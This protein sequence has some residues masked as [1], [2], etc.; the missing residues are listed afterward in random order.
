MNARAIV[1]GGALAFAAVLSVTPVAAEVTLL[2]AAGGGGGAGGIEFG[3]PGQI[4][5]SGGDSDGAGGV[6]GLGGG[7]TPSAPS[8]ANGAGGAGWLGPGASVIRPILGPPP[9]AAGGLSFPTFGGGLSISGADGG[10]GGGGGGGGQ[11]GGG[12]G[13]YSGGGG[14]AGGESGGGGGSYVSADFVDP[15][16]VAGSLGQFDVPSV[17]GWVEINGTV[18]GFTG[19]IAEY[20]VPAT[21]LYDILAEGAQGGASRTGFQNPGG[22]GAEVGGDIELT[23]GTELEIVVGG[24]GHIGNPAVLGGG[25]GGG[26]FVWIASTPSAAPEPSTWLMMAIG[27]AGLGWAARRA[28]RTRRGGLTGA[29]VGMIDAAA[30]R[31][32]LH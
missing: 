26:S 22:L 3:L 8:A 25:G 20:V 16:L 5:T 14:G 2:L 9:S 7:I 10:F 24:A 19:T 15:S 13:G 21:G 32:L 1:C 29:C 28:S 31:T 30:D 27:F 17:D 18:I 6:D 12:G 11:S 4:S 23:E